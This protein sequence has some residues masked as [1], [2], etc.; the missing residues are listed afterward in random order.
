LFI[1]GPETTSLYRRVLAELPQGARVLD[2]GSGEGYALVQLADDIRQKDLS[3]WCLDLDQAALERL[4]ERC[5]AA[6]LAD[7]I[8]AVQGD[9]LSWSPPEGTS[10]DA[11]LIVTTIVLLPGDIFEALGRAPWIKREAPLIV[12]NAAYTDRLLPRVARGV[13]GLF[14]KYVYYLGEPFELG[15]FEAKMRDE[16]LWTVQSVSK[17]SCWYSAFVDFLLVKLV[18]T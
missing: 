8:R 17:V 15:R 1:A 11:V 6:G 3:L 18:K 14:S 16:G 10:F 12:C 9:I 13:R 5:A 7:N 2:V 4:R